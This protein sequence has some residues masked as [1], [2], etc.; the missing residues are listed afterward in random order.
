MQNVCQI[1]LFHHVAIV[2]RKP[3]SLQIPEADYIPRIKDAKPLIDP[4]KLNFKGERLYRVVS[5]TEDARIVLDTGLTVRFLGVRLKN[6]ERTLK[7]LKDYLL[8]KQIILQ[9]D[10]NSPVDGNTVSAY[11]YLK[12]KIFANAY[13]IKAGLAEPD[14]GIRHRHRDKFLKLWQERRRVE[15]MDS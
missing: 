10:N 6:I 2:E 5:V 9:L 13:L 8:R 14:P 4:S 11:V 7:Y 12:N 15:R 1:P 3:G